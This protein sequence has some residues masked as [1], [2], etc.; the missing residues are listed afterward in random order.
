MAPSS[1]TI[2]TLDKLYEID[3]FSK[4]GIR[5]LDDVEYAR[6]GR[7]PSDSAHSRFIKT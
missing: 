4:V 6:D 3:W 7:M 2:G 5:D 1:Q